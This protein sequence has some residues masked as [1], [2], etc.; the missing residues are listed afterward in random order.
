[1]P[2]K[3]KSSRSTSVTHKKRRG[4]HHTQSK[5]YLKVY[6]PYVP[7]LLIVLVGLVF[8]SPQR[9]DQPGVLAYATEMSSGGLLAATNNQRAANGKASLTIHSSLNAAAQAKANDMIARNYWSHN[10]PDGEEPWIFI[11]ATGYSY[12]KA[13][14]NLAYGFSTSSETITGWMN[15]PTHR[16]NMLDSG[17][18][19]VGFGYANGA[20]YN[21]DG[22]ETVVVAMYAQPAAAAPVQAQQQVAPATTAPAQ[23]A[24]APAATAPTSEPAPTPAQAT[25]EDTAVATA[26]VAAEP[27]T[28]ARQNTA[29]PA[30]T[31][32]SKLQ[33]LT[34]GKAPWIAFAVGVFSGAALSYLG[35]KHSLAF[36]RRLIHGE[37]FLLHHPFLDI[38]LVA[39]VMVGYALSHTTG[40]I[41]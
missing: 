14:E 27:V 38:A 28:T 9:M 8:G 20:N 18:S 31:E 2:T 6:W 11:D 16:D 41:R 13:G 3:A 34:G 23:A 10:T 35:I 32:V 25:V 40:F 33:T 39:C 17:F 21:G 22:Q 4:D 30:T 19:E 24:P 15:S 1:M 7:I 5:H 29:E 36:K 12:T 37:Q 26:E